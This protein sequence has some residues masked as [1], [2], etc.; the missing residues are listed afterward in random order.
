MKKKK[1]L[2]L[3]LST[4]MA[5]TL[6][7]AAAFAA[8]D[9]A[10]SSGTGSAVV[11]TAAENQS[12]T[13]VLMNIPYADF[14]QAELGEDGAPVD[15]VT[16]ATKQKTRAGTLSGGSYHQDPEGTDISGVTFPVRVADGVDLSKYTEIKDD[17]SVEITVTLRGQTTTTTYEGKDALY[18][19]SDYSFY[20][21]SESDA[22][23]YY[24]EVSAAEDGSLVFSEVKGDVTVLN[25]ASASLYGYDRHT[26]MRVDVAGLPEDVETVYGV[27]LETK[28]GNSFGLHHVTNL[29]R[30]TQLGF[31]YYNA[32]GSES[33]YAG[34]FGS[35]LS[36]VTYYT[37]SGVY[38]IPADVTIPTAVTDAES[39]N[40]VRNNLSGDYV[41]V[42]DLDLSTED[43]WEPIGS[44][45]PNP[46]SDVPEQPNPA[47]AF[48]GTFMGNNHTIKVLTITAPMN[49]GLFGTVS[50][51][52]VVSNLNL[53]DVTI[54][55]TVM[56]GAAVGYV[57]GATIS[58]VN[59]TGT[60]NTIHG[61]VNMDFAGGG[62]MNGAPGMLGGIV[63]AAKD[64]EIINCKVSGLT[65]S[66]DGK[67][68]ASSVGESISN[69]GLLGGGLEDTTLE[70]CSVTDSTLIAVDYGYGL[71]GLA[72][73]AMGAEYVKNCTVDGVSIQ[74][75]DHS[76]LVGGMLGYTGKPDGA[77]EVS[78]NQVKN[79]TIHTGASSDRV[80]GLT[81]GGF[82]FEAYKE[83]YPA[84]TRFVIT[85]G[86]E[87]DTNTAVPS[88][89]D[90]II[91]TGSESAEPGE[92]SGH[93]AE[94]DQTGASAN[95]VIIDNCKAEAFADVDSDLWYHEA[96]DQA[97]ISGL[98]RGTGSDTFEPD[99]TTTRGMI[100][101]ILWRN[102][103]SPQAASAASFT[104]VAVDAWY[105]DAVAWAAENGIVNG[106]GDGNFG[107]EDT[108]TRE[109]LASMM[110][111]SSGS[112]DAEGSLDSFSDA[113]SVS[114][115]AA[116]ALSWAVENNIIRGMGDG[117]L[118]PQG[119]ASRAQTAQIFLNLKKIA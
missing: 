78:G 112:P 18:E 16:S 68:D 39:L 2:S 92:L 102:A 119:N 113:S 56:T 96:I 49:G 35:T 70:G 44:Y 25:D 118:Q 98:M 103:G 67:E 38:E 32:D 47:R 1:V 116:A 85:D 37:N 20:R 3:V 73:C 76:D 55:S 59:L 93:A 72:G 63:G 40:A 75:G 41:L 90:T 19:S 107:P 80:G 30:N 33:S 36:K 77:T 8:G 71:G 42:A 60:N 101:S 34:L 58:S 61:V 82:Y 84:P 91:L 46:D 51:D 86:T 104:D 10:P 74:T 83:Y 17:A 21:L 6:T 108:I 57:N 15:A 81:G 12:G 24:K 111:R 27:V 89:S 26:D 13:Y 14:Y 50:D 11:Q 28:E 100:A 66:L 99:T 110:Y 43:A 9:E 69:A 23:A 114:D 64:A 5:L 29:W 31:P 4:A 87:G 109:Q 79:T 97:V 94:A 54:T 65:L 22:P 52:A 48:T 115:W 117:S 88:V 105:A 45:E 62:E 53:S 106:Y 95:N 7:P